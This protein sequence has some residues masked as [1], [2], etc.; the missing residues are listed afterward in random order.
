MNKSLYN[1][2]VMLP[3]SLIKHLTDCFNSVNGNSNVEGFN[4]NQELRQSKQTTYQ[5]L[6]RIKNWFDSY[7]GKKED[8]PFILNGGDRMKQW[9][10]HAL[11]QMRSQVSN[12][13]KIKSDGG[14]QNQYID[15]HQKDG[16]NVAD[17]HTTTLSD[18]K[19]EQE[20]NKINKLI[21]LI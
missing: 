12:S 4:R 7:T 17:K 10:D 19:L 20:I 1:Q 8:A 9:C 18:L 6:K 5:Q 11:T 13:K 21:K 2:I 14:M 3:D 15:S 16:I